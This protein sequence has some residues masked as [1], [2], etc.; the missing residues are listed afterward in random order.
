MLIQQNISVQPKEKHIPFIKIY[1]HIPLSTVNCVSKYLYIL[2]WKKR[3]IFSPESH[4]GQKKK[5]RKQ[6]LT[7]STSLH[8]SEHD[9]T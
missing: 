8:F 1:T 2:K 5:K 9:C 6:T 3:V 4:P 7:L